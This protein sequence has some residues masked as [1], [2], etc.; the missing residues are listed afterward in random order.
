MIL[1]CGG[2]C[3][4]N[5]PRVFSS[6]RALSYT[7]RFLVIG[8]LLRRLDMFVN[9]LRRRY[10]TIEYLRIMKTDTSDLSS[11]AE[12]RSIHSF[13]HALTTCIENIRL[14]LSKFPEYTPARIPLN[15]SAL[16]L[17][18]EEFEDVLEA[19]ASLCGRVGFLAFF[20]S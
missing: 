14:Q 6:Y 1:S 15:T 3:L 10:V 11:R 9:S 5:H 13:A 4:Q 18:H 12:G 19:I 2:I 8:S 7:K 17:D 16:F 20:L